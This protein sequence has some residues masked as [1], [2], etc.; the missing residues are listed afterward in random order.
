M[1]SCVGDDFRD[2][3]LDFLPDLLGVKRTCNCGYDYSETRK[4]RRNRN[5][6]DFKT[7]SN[8]QHSYFEIMVI[9]RRI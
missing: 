7:I 2:F 3:D 9:N 8:F 5:F 4:N 1:T 6:T